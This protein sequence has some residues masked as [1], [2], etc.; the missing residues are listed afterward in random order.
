MAGCK[1]GCQGGGNLVVGNEANEF[2]K[3]VEVGLG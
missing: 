2:G 3:P 1:G